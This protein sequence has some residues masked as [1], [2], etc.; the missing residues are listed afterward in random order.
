MKGKAKTA[1]AVIGGYLVGRHRSLRAVVVAAVAAVVGG[2]NPAVRRGAKRLSN[3]DLLG[4]IVP[5][6]VRKLL[7]HA[8]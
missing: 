4:R 3:S 2:K 1:M 8:A 7:R 6:P 5:S